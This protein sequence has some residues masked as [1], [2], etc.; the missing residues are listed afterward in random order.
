[1]PI[2]EMRVGRSI[3]VPDRWWLG[4]S[5]LSD[6]LATPA[7]NPGL[8]HFRQ[9]RSSRHFVDADDTEQQV[10]PAAQL[11]VLVDRLANGPATVSWLGVCSGN[12]ITLW[13]IFTWV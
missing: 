5:P 2:L 6:H 7:Q 11:S 1:M 3:E 13:L 9:E 4:L 12:G 8:R 10:A